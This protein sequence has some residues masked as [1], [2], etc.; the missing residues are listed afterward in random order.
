MPQL[1]LSRTYAAFS[2][3]STFTGPACFGRIKGVDLILIPTYVPLLTPVRFL[4]NQFPSASVV[5]MLEML[6]GVSSSRVAT[7]T[8]E[9]LALE[10]PLCPQGDSGP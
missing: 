8:T 2:E 7:V 5:Y 10:S 3:S 4:N 9:P 1:T 6:T